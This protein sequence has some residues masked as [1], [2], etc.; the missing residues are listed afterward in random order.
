[1]VLAVETVGR[2]G[3]TLGSIAKYASFYMAF[4]GREVF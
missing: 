1:M 4:R 3:K 2:W